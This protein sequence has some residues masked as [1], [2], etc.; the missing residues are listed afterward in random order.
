MVDYGMGPVAALQA[1][2][3]IAGRILH[4]P[5]GEVKRG[6][7]ADLIAVAGDPARDI[8]AL[9]QVRFVMKGGVV[10]KQ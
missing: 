9:R 10:Y 7:L 2:T 4:M 1:A 5:I 3:S 6:M 8:K